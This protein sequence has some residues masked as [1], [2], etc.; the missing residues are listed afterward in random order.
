[1]IF[2]SLLEMTPVSQSY[3]QDFIIIYNYMKP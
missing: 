2:F 1:M 3:K